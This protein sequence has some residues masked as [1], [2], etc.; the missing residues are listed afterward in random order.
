GCRFCLFSDTNFYNPSLFYKSQD[1]LVYYLYNSDNDF[2]FPFITVKYFLK[3]KND[4]IGNKFVLRGKNWE[5]PTSSII[6]IKSGNPIKN[7]SSGGV[8]TCIDV[9]IDERD[10]NISLVLENTSK[11]QILL[12]V[13]TARNNDFVFNYEQAEL[14]KKKFG[15]EKWAK[16]VDGKVSIGM[17]KEMCEV[18]W[19]KPQYINKTITAN[20]S[21]EQWVYSD[22]YLYFDKGI[23]TA[24][25]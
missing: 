23:L 7:F 21:S 17:T 8:W 12:E 16:I 19:G 6:D 13:N 20:K 25:Q 14:Y 24:M 18:S 22:N 4:N 11:E 2:S 1:D 5:S 3:I 10:S 15:S 9:S